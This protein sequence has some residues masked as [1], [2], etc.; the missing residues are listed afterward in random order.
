MKKTKAPN[1]F[2]LSGLQKKASQLFKLNLK[3]TLNIAQSLYDKKILTYPRTDTPAITQS[4]YDYLL[5]K[6]R[7]IK[8][9]L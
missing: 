4:E 9:N 5:N 6:L 2:S 7:R 1:L 8:I 3:E